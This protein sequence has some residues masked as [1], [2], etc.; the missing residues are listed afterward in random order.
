MSKHVASRAQEGNESI[1]RGTSGNLRVGLHLA[2]RREMKEV[3]SY[4]RPL[5]RR[6]HLAHRREMKV[7]VF[8]KP[9][10]PLSLH[11]A[12]RRE[13]KAKT[14]NAANEAVK[15]HLAH[16][17]EMKVVSRG[18]FVISCLRCISRTGGK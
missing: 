11:L 13:M 6:L 4:E 7:S 17:R 9:N 8:Y 10:L 3:S 14:L 18:L 12:H 1:Y 5:P 15:L 2:H 16:R